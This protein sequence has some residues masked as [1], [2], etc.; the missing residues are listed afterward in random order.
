MP[1]ADGARGDGV[2]EAAALTTLHEGFMFKGSTRSSQLRGARHYFVLR[3]D[4]TITYFDT[5][6]LADTGEPLHPPASLVGAR[7][8]EKSNFVPEALQ[9]STQR[10]PES[11]IR[12]D[13]QGGEKMVLTVES[14][15][16]ATRW[17]DVLLSCGATRVRGSTV[18]VV[19]PP[20]KP[21]QA[22]ATPTDQ[23]R[24]PAP[25]PRSI[26][27]QLAARAAA[28][29]MVAEKRA[30]ALAKVQAAQQ[31]RAQAQAQ[32]GA[33]KRAVEVA[34]AK[35]QVLPSPVSLPPPA[36]PAL[37]TAP[38]PA[39]APAP[40]PAVDP[41][42]APSQ[43]PSQAPIQA[44]ERASEQAPE[45]VP[46]PATE[47]A[48]SPPPVPTP[49]LAAGMSLDALLGDD[50]DDDGSP[51]R[52][53]TVADDKYTAPAPVAAPAPVPPP[54]PEA[55]EAEET[56]KPLVAALLTCPPRVD[57]V[58][59]LLSNALENEMKPIANF[60]EGATVFALSKMWSDAVA[61]F[62][63]GLHPIPHCG[64]FLDVECTPE[65]SATDLFLYAAAC[66]PVGGLLKHLVESTGL[67]AYPG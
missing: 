7:L 16:E 67:T 30:L 6:S 48:T 24:A 32:L 62:G 56:T 47:Q 36:P 31:A 60:V 19:S 23:P 33:E 37:A 46:A 44:P 38:A 58:R 28:E 8:L 54:A 9:Q 63:L 66:M 11:V 10:N 59:G 12:L 53:D 29:K 13:L 55:A 4:K 18:G 34:K 35:A 26:Q 61:T 43:A 39:Q 64:G 21:E 14:P 45:Q 15:E 2:N 42:S 1:M 25:K 65:G 3:S 49:A 50:T 5:D 40:A 52:R 51:R 41:T 57:E 27:E 20:D 17:V 22:Q